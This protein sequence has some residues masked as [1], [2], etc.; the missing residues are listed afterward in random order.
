MDYNYF[1]VVKSLKNNTSD[2]NNSI[3]EYFPSRTPL[4]MA[5]VPFQF[6]TDIYDE[7]QAF[8]R[9]TLFPEL[10]YPFEQDEEVTSRE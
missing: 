5:Y 8:K 9:G 1:D 2:S 7:K 4:G 3:S 10:D 6:W